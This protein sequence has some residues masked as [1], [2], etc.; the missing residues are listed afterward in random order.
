MT[1]NEMLKQIFEKVT[2]LDAKVSGLDTKVSG[3]DAKVS[4][5]ESD[6]KTVKNR[7]DKIDSEVSALRVGQIELHKEIKQVDKRVS[8]TYNLALEAWGTSTEN[9]KWLETAN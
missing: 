7:L 9:R 8:E 5:L 3:L 4:S 1:D 2:D 6:M